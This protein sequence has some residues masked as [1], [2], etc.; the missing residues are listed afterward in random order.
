MLMIDS[1]M[2]MNCMFPG[3]LHGVHWG[4]GHGCGE[5][6]GGF[7]ISSIGAKMTFGIFGIISVVDLILFVIV[8]TLHDKCC[9]REENRHVDQSEYSQL[10]Q[11][12]CCDS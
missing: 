12:P 9:P 10:P 1:L 6:A 3:V 11:K 8:N 7:L 4:L 5:L 2:M